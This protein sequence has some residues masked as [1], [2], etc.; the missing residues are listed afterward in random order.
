MHVKDVSECQV[1][2]GNV[3]AP[4]ARCVSIEG[5]PSAI[6]SEPMVLAMLQQAGL[7]EE[8]VTF[9]TCEGDPC[10]E[11]HVSFS[12]VD[13]ALRCVYHFEGCQWD[14]S[15]TEV[16]AKMT[17]L[18]SCESPQSLNYALGMDAAIHYVCC[19]ATE[20]EEHLGAMT[21]EQACEI[22]QEPLG[23]MAQEEAGGVLQE[24]A[25]AMLSAQAAE[26]IPGV[27]ESQQSPGVRGANAPESQQP[28]GVLRADAPAFE[29]MPG[30]SMIYELLPEVYEMVDAEAC[31]FMTLHRSDCMAAFA[32][33]A[34][35]TLLSADSPP[36]VPR[37][38]I[39][40][41]ARAESRPLAKEEGHPSSDTSTE[42]WESDVDDEK[43][44]L[45]V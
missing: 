28:P 23:A 38:P 10:G 12:S 14:A 40:V 37:P 2:S 18:K 45:V 8:V 1:C 9:S 27:A 42:L 4:I 29:A 34:H 6:L 13:S 7:L 35:D 19:S 20:G 22:V 21:Q 3:L 24:R 32:C 26:F 11:A 31:D 30:D 33:E 15:G 16:T 41:A 43:G 25:V 17:A 5:L 39:L 44:G 36:F